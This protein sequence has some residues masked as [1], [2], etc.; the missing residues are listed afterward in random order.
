MIIITNNMF[1]S[2]F[3][4]NDMIR[5]LQDQSHFIMKLVNN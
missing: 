5:M 1:K 4:Q 2:T 3:D